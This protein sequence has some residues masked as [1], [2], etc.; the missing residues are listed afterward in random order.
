M[1]RYYSARPSSTNVG[2]L[3]CILWELDPTKNPR[4]GTLN[5]QKPLT[6]GGP[7]FNTYA[8][9]CYKRILTELEVPDVFKQWETL[10]LEKN[11]NKDQLEHKFDCLLKSFEKK[12]TTYK[13]NQ[14]AFDIY[15][16]MIEKEKEKLFK[17][18]TLP[19]VNGKI[20]VNRN[21]FGTI[22][23]PRKTRAASAPVK[24]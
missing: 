8:K 11:L 22:L 9:A 3:D 21:K 23:Y 13:L 24:K 2:G 19:V 1:S 12:L 15:S 7:I 5:V 18:Y 14:A 16:K 10:V 20:Q 4:T 17:L 6:E